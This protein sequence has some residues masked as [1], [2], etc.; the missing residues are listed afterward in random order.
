ML[1]QR[2]HGPLPI[3]IT[4]RMSDPTVTPLK[5]APKQMEGLL[6]CR[7][8]KFVLFSGPRKSAKSM[9]ALTA[10]CDHAWETPHGEVALV[11]VSQTSGLQS[12]MWD[13]LVDGI[14]PKYMAL[15]KGM[16]W[17]REPFTAQSSKR[18]TCVVTNKFGGRCRFQLE[19]LKDEREVEERFKNK[20]YTAVFVTELSNFRQRKTFSIWSQTL[21]SIHGLD[22]KQ[23]LF[24]GDTNPSDEGDESWIYHLWFVRRTQTY[25][26]YCEFQAER[27]LPISSEPDFQALNAQ[28]GLLQ[29]EIADN[30][31][32][33]DAEVSELIEEHCHDQD[34]YDR[35]IL[36]KWVKASTTALFHKHFREGI[37]VAGELETPGNPDPMMLV[38]QDQTWKL[39]LSIDPGTSANSAGYIFEK[40]ILDLGKGRLSLPIFSIL[41]ETAIIGEDHTVDEFTLML[42]ERM[43][44]W[45]Q[46]TGR[47]YEWAAW[48]DRSVFEHRDNSS[49]KYYHQLIFEA[50]ARFWRQKYEQ[51]QTVQYADRAIVLQAADRSP[52]SLPHRVDLAR[53]LM[54]EQ[55]LIVSRTRCPRL[56]QCF[57]SMPAAKN[58]PNVPPKGHHLKHGFDGCFYGVAEESYSEASSAVIRTL[59]NRENQSES[60]LVSI[61]M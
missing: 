17:I 23:F 3:A 39:Y 38:P 26:Q 43:F 16:K 24:L 25:E 30:I 52:K 32:L 19:S 12:G 11:A 60:G 47:I 46:Y 42:C 59:R 33:T 6:L 15:D 34:L 27:A 50:S 10:L 51:T 61:S 18:P 56:I 49:G 31:F 21:R 9:G 36:G 48:S 57:K 29:F 20:N 14:M 40:V 44:W 55:R 1:G 4:F 28:L 54:Y 22:P 7:Q 5:I 37:H 58:D 13:Q 35:Y 45:E 53:R 2:N 8:K 41:D